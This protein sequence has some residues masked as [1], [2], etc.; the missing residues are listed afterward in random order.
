M[1][2][3]LPLWLHWE[4]GKQL[5]FSYF[6]RGLSVLERLDCLPNAIQ[7]RS[8]ETKPEA[9]SLVYWL[10]LLCSPIVTAERARYLF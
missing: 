4:V 2:L 1:N 7:F 5:F 8:A 3:L 6:Y 10:V 9:M